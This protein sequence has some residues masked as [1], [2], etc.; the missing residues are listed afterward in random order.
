ME[1]LPGDHFLLLP[2]NP[3]CP[4]PPHHKNKTQY[5]TLNFQFSMITY[6]RYVS[7]SLVVLTHCVNQARI[8]ELL[9]RLL[10]E[11]QQSYSNHITLY[12]A[13]LIS[14]SF[15]LYL[16]NNTL[17]TNAISINERLD[18]CNLQNRVCYFFRSLCF[19]TDNLIL[20][21]KL[22]WKWFIGLQIN[23]IEKRRNSRTWHK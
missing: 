20:H 6:I 2:A 10:C 14:L 17:I 11:E 19:C 1:K 4:H 23:K 7:P 8:L 5:S 3:P 13:C 22:I 21:R 9:W 18:L 12:C 16:F 15:H